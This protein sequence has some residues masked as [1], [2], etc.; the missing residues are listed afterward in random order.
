M[1]RPGTDTTAQ[2][3]PNPSHFQKENIFSIR[4]IWIARNAGLRALSIGTGA[5]CVD[6]AQTPPLRPG[7]E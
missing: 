5:A 4:N 7:F 1:E 3:L 2:K 6:C